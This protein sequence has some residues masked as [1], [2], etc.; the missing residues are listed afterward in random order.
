MTEYLDLYLKVHGKNGHIGFLFL[1]GALCF[2]IFKDQADSYPVAFFK[3]IPNSGK[4]TMAK[5]LGAFFGGA[6]MLN[7][8]KSNTMASINAH[9]SQAAS[10]M[11]F[12]NEFNYSN[13]TNSFP[14]FIKYIKAAWDMEGR[15]RI[16]DI[17]TNQTEE[18]EMDSIMVLLGQEDVPERSVMQRV[19]IA[20]FLTNVYTAEENESY[21]NLRELENK[22]LT[23]LTN[24]IIGHRKLIAAKLKD[25]MTWA[26]GKLKEQVSVLADQRFFSNW[27]SLL[28]PMFILLKEGKIDYPMN[29]SAWL[30]FAVERIEHQVKEM[31]EEG[32]AAIFFE[33]LMHEFSAKNPR[34]DDRT[35]Y[36]EK[37]ELRVQ[38]RAV[39]EHFSAYLQ[40]TGK[41]K[42]LENTGKKFLKEDLMNHVAFQK[43][44]KKN[45]YVGFERNAQGLVVY[46]HNGQPK[47]RRTSA[48][49]FNYEEL[50]AKGLEITQPDFGQIKV[51]DAQILMKAVK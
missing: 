1:I 19:V 32:L 20:E 2:D 37:G 33:F 31:K 29:I 41:A 46:D 8:E 50:Q 36:V 11:A 39:Y 42:S 6:D 18:V 12:F 5:S 45:C 24:E 30:D 17:T 35:V 10:A 15:K 44:E 34:L 38:F 14:A 13:I 25:A 21:L 27:S 28:A 4:G 40:R 9:V 26:N 3:G 49:I 51:D 43:E 47:P 7:L 22:G 48:L 23:H 16:K